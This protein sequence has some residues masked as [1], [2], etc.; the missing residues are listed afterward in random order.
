MHRGRIIGGVIGLV[1]LSA[2]L[3]LPFSDVV[4]GHTSSPE[5]LWYIFTHYI[6]NLGSVTAQNNTVLM[7]FTF[8][9][10]IAAILLIVASLVGIYPLASGILGVIGLSF[11]TFGPYEVIAD[12]GA[13]P[14]IFGVGFYLIWTLSIL[15]LV[16]GYWTWRGERRAK[17]LAEV[18]TIRQPSPSVVRSTTVRRYQRVDQRGTSQLP[19]VCPMCG[20]PNPVNAIVCRKCASPL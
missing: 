18:A 4:T 17:R 11:A 7:S 15:E 14:V 12:Y 1:M 16:V 8:L 10:Q 6:D 3:A 2:V 19:V 20:E 9:Y 5:S 13:N